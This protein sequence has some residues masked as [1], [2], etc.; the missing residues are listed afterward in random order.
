[1][2]QQA[3]VPTKEELIT[4]RECAIAQKQIDDALTWFSEQQEHILQELQ[5]SAQTVNVKT[6]GFFVPRV[7]ENRY[8]LLKDWLF[9]SE[10]ICHFSS[11]AGGFNIAIDL[12]F[13]PQ[14]DDN[15]V[16]VT[17]P[18][19]LGLVGT[20]SDK[21]TSDTLNSAEADI[22]SPTFRQVYRFDD[23]DQSNDNKLSDQVGDDQKMPVQSKN[24]E[25][26]PQDLHDLRQKVVTTLE[27]QNAE[28]KTK[29]T[30]ED[31]EWLNK[32]KIEVMT[33]FKKDAETPANKRCSAVIQNTNAHRDLKLLA[34]LGK[35]GYN[36]SLS[37]SV[38]TPNGKNL[39]FKLC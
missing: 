16:T 14:L 38:F 2:T 6:L 29:W 17:E 15:N 19:V 12:S 21:S 11:S 13:L 4:L 34:W 25:L 22:V 30:E 10:L 3:T 26:T 36:C 20:S 37:P 7:H 9:K 32:T 8:H 23:H 18:K 5:Y 31:E 27:Q 1:M 24:I 33:S 28:S 35:L 39:T